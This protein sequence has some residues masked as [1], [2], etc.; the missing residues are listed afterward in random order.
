MRYVSDKYMYNLQGQF[1]Q[2]TLMAPP[3][4][5][6]ELHYLNKEDRL[7]R[8][9]VRKHR[10]AVYG[11]DFLNDQNDSEHESDREEHTYEEEGKS[12]SNAEFIYEDDDD[13]D[14]MDDYEDEDDGGNEKK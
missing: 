7:L 14:E 8:W 4:F 12:E 9:L 3:S 2:M 11:L 13:L 10:D 6:Q 5:P 1:V